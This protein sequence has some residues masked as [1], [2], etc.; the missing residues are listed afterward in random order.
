MEEKKNNREDYKVK[1]INLR[2][3]ISAISFVIGIILFYHWIINLNYSL[4][5][6]ALYLPALGII[7]I[8][9]GISMIIF[10]EL[11]M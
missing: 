4:T 1:N 5:G 2:I 8:I 6:Y 9:S 7:T 11:L 3:L 10:G